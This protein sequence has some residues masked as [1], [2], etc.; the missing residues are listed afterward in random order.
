MFLKQAI[1]R[2]A[3]GF[4]AEDEDENSPPDSTQVML[5]RAKEIALKNLSMQPKKIHLQILQEM[6]MKYSIFKGVSNTKIISRIK[7]SRSKSN[8][9]DIYRTIEMENLAKVKNSNLF[10]YILISLSPMNMME[11]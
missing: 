7:N 11:N 10:F 1:Y 6:E 5:E 3:M 2:K 9:N 8:G 4:I